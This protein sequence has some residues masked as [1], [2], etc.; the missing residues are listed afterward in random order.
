MKLSPVELR[1]G[2][3][4]RQ[5]SNRTCLQ[6]GSAVHSASGEPEIPPNRQVDI[7]TTGRALG[8]KPGTG[9]GVVPGT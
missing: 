8:H 5:A 2:R 6:K 1:D 7:P 9:L 3:E 4:S